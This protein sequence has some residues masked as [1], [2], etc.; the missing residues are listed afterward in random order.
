MAE[1]TIELGGKI[2]LAGF[3]DIDPG[4]LVV[5]KKVV[6]NYVRKIEKRHSDFQEIKIHLKTIHNSECE[7]Q[8][9]LVIGGE[10]KNA[11]VTDFNLFL[12]LDKAL[13]KVFSGDS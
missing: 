4:Q 5:V 3:R 7:I 13:G 10:T 8:I 9:N 6:G 1:D 12:A 2:Q 11:E